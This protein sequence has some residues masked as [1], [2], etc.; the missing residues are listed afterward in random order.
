LAVML[1]RAVRKP[2]FNQHRQ[3]EKNY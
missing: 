1:K 3:N 2:K